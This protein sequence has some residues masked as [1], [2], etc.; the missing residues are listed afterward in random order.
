MPIPSHPAG[1]AMLLAAMLACSGAAAAA[2]RS[3]AETG[4]R[5]PTME[6]ERSLGRSLPGVRQPRPGLVTGGQPAPEAWPALAARGVRTVINLRTPAEMAGRDEAREVAAAGMRYHALPVAGAGD[7]DERRA[8]A[9]WRL[10]ESAPGTVAVHCASGNR[11]GALL[12][13]AAA[14]HGGMD[15]EAALRFGKSAGLGGLEATVRE[16]LGLAPESE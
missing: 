4:A 12:A 9:L 7:L 10:I 11:V 5:Q 8:A 6:L 15:A 1:A 3:P 14:E 16:R 13:L 2:D